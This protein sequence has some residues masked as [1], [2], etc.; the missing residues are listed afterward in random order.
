MSAA[1]AGAVRRV[2]AVFLGR[3][4]QRVEAG[5]ADHTDQFRHAPTLGRPRVA[6][7]ERKHYDAEHLAFGDAFRTFVD[8]SIVPHYLDWESAGMTPREVFPEAGKSGFLGMAVPEELRRRRRRRLP[9]QPDPRRADRVRP[10]SVAP[11]SGSTLH[12]DICLPY[13]LSYADDGQRKRWLP[14]I[15]SG[16]LITAVA[17]TEPGPV[18]TSPA[19][20]PAPCATATAMWSTARR[21]SSPTASTPTWSSPR[22]APATTRTTAAAACRCSSSS[23]AWTASSGAAT[24]TSSACTPRTPPSCRSPTFG[25]RSANRLGDEGEG[26][27]N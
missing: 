13:F 17:M 7:M 2:D 16:E 4:E 10:G 14:G 27:G 5:A 3:L 18:P 21:R 8:K 23:G 20:A 15:V 24:S 22:C 26:F 25:C 11:G 6:G 1:L 9:V 12:N 19:S